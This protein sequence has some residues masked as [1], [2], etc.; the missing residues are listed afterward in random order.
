V[1]RYL[2]ELREHLRADASVLN[3]IRETGDLPDDLRERLD[4]ALQA[5]AKVFKASEEAAVAA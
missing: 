3:E 4:Q 2:E 5:F 1:P